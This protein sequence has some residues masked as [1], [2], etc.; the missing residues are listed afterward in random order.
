MTTPVITA[1]KRNCPQ[2]WLTYVVEEPFREIVEGHPYLDEIIVLPRKQKTKDLIQS[3]R[4]IRKTKYD[5]LIDLFGGPKA[6]WITLF[7]KAKLKIGYAVKYKSFIYQIRISRR[8][9][10]DPIHSV[11]NHMNLVRALGIKVDPIPSL[12]VPDASDK[13]KEKV[14]RF[15][16]ENDLIDSKMIALHIGAGNDF[17]DW[18]MDHLMELTKLLTQRPDTRIVLVGASQ[19]QIRA[20]RMIKNSKAPIFSLVGKL[21]L[22]ELREL[23]SRA[24]LFVG[25]DS[26]PM[27]LAASTETPIVAYFGPTLP[28]LFRPWQARA[29][30]IEKDYECRFKC[31]QR[32]CMY[33]DF[34]CIQTITPQEV[35]NACLEFL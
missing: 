7:A 1:L 8:S 4:Q 18:G 14:S 29:I 16:E 11:E 9:K 23:I 28:A 33:D 2:A 26:G 10:E 15:F 22:K 24:D 31:G 3:I 35:F 5:V 17:R 6:A 12:L 13:E 19:D 32:K 30:I 21:G 34:R 27:H 20:E 25:P